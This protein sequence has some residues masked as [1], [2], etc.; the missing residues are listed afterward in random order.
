MGIREKIRKRW[1]TKDERRQRRQ[2]EAYA[3]LVEEEKRLDNKLK[4]MKKKEAVR[5]KKIEANPILRRISKMKPKPQPM[6]PPK[7]KTKKKRRRKKRSPAKAP[8][9]EPRYELPDLTGGTDRKKKRGLPK[10]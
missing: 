2:D 4:L 1:D 9:R 10:L 7:K 6:Q 3:R 5:K 8:E